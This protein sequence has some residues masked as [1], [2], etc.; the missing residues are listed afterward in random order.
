MNILRATLED[1]EDI[2]LLGVSEPS[3]KVSEGIRFY[4][5]PYFIT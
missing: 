1:V 4:E 2:Y 5:N 3:F